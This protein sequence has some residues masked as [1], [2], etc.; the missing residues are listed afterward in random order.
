[1]D[2][3][4]AQ[5]QQSPREPTIELRQRLLLHGLRARI[6]QVGHRFGLQQI[7]P[8]VE[9]RAPREFTRLRETRTRSDTRSEHPLWRHETAVD[10]QLH[11]I[12]AR[13]GLRFHEHGDERVLHHDAGGVAQRRPLRAPRYDVGTRRPA[14][15]TEGARDGYRAR[16]RK[17]NQCH[18]AT[19][20]SRGD[21]HDRVVV[22]GQ[23]RRHA[24]VIPARSACAAPGK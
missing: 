13:V 22:A 17:S 9:H 15:R 23:Q 7:H 4:V 18:R 24:R 5:C 10:R 21:R 1:M 2:H 6:H 19:P 14:E 16:P 8:S 20:R 3:L 12:L 11:H